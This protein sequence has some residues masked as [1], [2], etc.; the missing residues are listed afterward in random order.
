MPHIY[1]IERQEDFYPEVMKE[2]IYPVSLKQDFSV[3]EGAVGRNF[4][5]P[6][7]PYLDAGRQASLQMNLPSDILYL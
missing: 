1:V 2:S 3:C 6:M 4:S 5:L 7:P